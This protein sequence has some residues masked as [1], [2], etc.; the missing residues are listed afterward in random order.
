M[1]LEIE[2]E[3]TPIPTPDGDLIHVVTQ[4]KVRYGERTEWI[5]IFD[6]EKWDEFRTLIENPVDITEIKEIQKRMKTKE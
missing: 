4:C 2:R 3:L 5:S 1:R 6:K